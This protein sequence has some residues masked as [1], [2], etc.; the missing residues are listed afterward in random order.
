MRGFART[1]HMSMEVRLHA[2]KAR[3]GHGAHSM[4]SVRRM[5]WNMS[6]IDRNMTVRYPSKT[7][8]VRS[9]VFPLSWNRH[10]CALLGFVRRRGI[11]SCEIRVA[12][13]NVQPVPQYLRNGG[14]LVPTICRLPVFCCQNGPIYRAYRPSS[15]MRGETAGWMVECYPCPT[16]GHV[17]LYAAVHGSRGRIR[18]A[19]K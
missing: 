12:A 13:N 3:S 4:E 16:S 14:I 2:P 5:R 17:R 15:M 7:T 8:P 19:R 6:A 11:L 9:E 10:L 1:H 18:L